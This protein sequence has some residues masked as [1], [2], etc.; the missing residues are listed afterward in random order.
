M[1]CYS[2]TIDN[3]V[4]GTDETIGFHTAL[5]NIIDA[6][7]KLRDTSSLHHHCFVVEVMGNHAD[8]LAIYSAI[9]CDSEI[10]ITDKTEYDENKKLLKN[11]K[12][13]KKSIIKNIRYLL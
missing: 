6:V 12:F 10:V 4:N 2:G 8:N 9:A 11:L 5:Y 1:Y 13:V 3:D 7:N